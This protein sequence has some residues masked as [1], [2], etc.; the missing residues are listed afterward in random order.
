MYW[1][2]P[3]G[4]IGAGA[5]IYK[6]LNDSAG[7]K[8]SEWEIKYRQVQDSIESHRKNIEDHLRRAQESYDFDLL[9]SL[10][11]SSVRVADEAYKLLSDSK[12]S[13]QAI[14][15]ALQK[16]KFKILELKTLRSLSS[17]ENYRSIS[18]EIDG[19]YKLRES[20][21]PDKDALKEQ[22]NNFLSEVK[23]LNNQT[24][25]LKEAIRDR[26]G[27]RGK[28]W[29]AKLALRVAEKKILA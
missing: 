9:I 27:L 3:I 19:L 1:L 10:H 4:I 5:L 2:I 20:L 18:E 25:M 26:T 21:F 22:R 15:D 6:A 23:R 29:Y 24:R 16:A 12:D 11:Y 14:N 7:E 28:L 8:R 17:K 13:L